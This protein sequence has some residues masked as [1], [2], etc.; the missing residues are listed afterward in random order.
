MVGRCA[1]RNISRALTVVVLIAQLFAITHYHFRLSA[2]QYSATVT[3]GLDDGVCALC[4]F[5][6]CS[7][8]TVTTSRFPIA[9]TVIGH[10]DLYA[11]QSWPLYSFNSYLPGRSPPASA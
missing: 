5:H 10:I 8:S 4:L 11:A 3:I 2:S 1:T 7:A 9:L 6:N